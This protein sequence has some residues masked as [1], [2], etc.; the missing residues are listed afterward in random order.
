MISFVI[1]L[2]ALVI[3]YFT[4][5]AFVSKVFGADGSRQTPC[6]THQDGVD[7][8]PMPTWKVYMIQ[9]LNIA[10]VGPIFGAI[11]GAQFG[12]ASYLWIVLGTIFAGATHDYLAAMISLRQDG[13]SLSEIIGTYL[14]KKIRVVMSI[15]MVVLLVLVGAVFT[16]SPASILGAMTKDLVGNDSLNLYGWIVVI[17]VYYI[18]ATLCPVD[19]I[20]GKIYPFFAFCLI[21]MAVGIGC[22]ILVKQPTLTEWWDDGTF[23]NGKWMAE[24]HLTH[25]F[26]MMFISIACGAISGF[27]ATQSPLM[28]RCIKNERMGRPC[29]YGAMVTEGIVAL[30][31]AAAA[32]Y[33]F[34]EHGLV[35][36]ATGKGYDGGTVAT[37]I[38]KNWLGW[39]GGILALIGVAVAPISS[40][41]TALRSARLIIA[42]FL[43]V[44]QKSMRSRLLI[45]VPMFVVTAAILVWSM[46]DK[47]GFGMLWRYFGWSNQLLSVFTLW[48]ITI[49]LK[50]NKTGFWYVM[51]L[52]PAM[53]MTTVCSSFILMLEKGGLGLDYTV[54]IVIGVVLACVCAVL[55]L[56]KK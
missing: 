7:Y 9:F 50:R 33:F 31:W 48:A 22:Y 18:V 32:T 54:S 12:T 8:I 46:T 26:P 55:A 28:A 11:M 53:F 10:G 40:G 41:D 56:K 14:G 29:F 3:G 20:I 47:N 17:F 45:A 30:V 34:N 19:K 13:A 42:D 24:G 2:L 27:H 35:N 36:E 25:L 21:F 5:G 16:S 51:T 15:F 37:L 44:E 6:Y 52:L 43:H 49:Y 38:S 1:A 4:Y 23:V 39:L